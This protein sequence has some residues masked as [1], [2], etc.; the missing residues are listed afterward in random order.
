MPMME[1][2]TENFLFRV[3]RRTGREGKHVRSPEKHSKENPKHCAH[4]VPVSCR[5]LYFPITA[6]RWQGERRRIF[7]SRH[8]KRTRRA[9]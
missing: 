7:M 9:D 5:R 3:S 1:K 6:F 8:K 2:A 4:G